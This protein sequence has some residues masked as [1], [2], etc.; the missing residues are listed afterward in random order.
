[1]RLPIAGQSTPQDVRTFVPAHSLPRALVI[2]TDPGMSAW[3]LLEGVSVPIYRV[4]EAE[5]WT[6]REVLQPMV[7]QELAGTPSAI[8][9]RLQGQKCIL[10]GDWVASWA[11]VACRI[12]LTKS[13]I[14]STERR[15][16]PW[17]L[18]LSDVRPRV[19]EALLRTI[20]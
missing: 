11:N 5:S 18:V 14:R 16:T 2:V 13:N 3:P 20:R 8:T 10:L 19:V 9:A 17:D 1:M 6:Q 12:R 4:S 15:S 7:H